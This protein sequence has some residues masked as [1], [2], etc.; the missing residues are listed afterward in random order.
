MEV[1]VFALLK[2]EGRVG[3]ALAYRRA[4][5]SLV[6]YRFGALLLATGGAGKMYRVTSNSW[7]STGDGTLFRLTLPARPFVAGTMEPQPAPAPVAAA[8]VKVGRV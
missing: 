4:D 6:L 3:G 1:T 8:K 7:E 2:S 5:G